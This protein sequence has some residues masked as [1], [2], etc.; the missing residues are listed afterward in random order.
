MSLDSRHFIAVLAVITALILVFFFMRGPAH[1][2]NFS[3]AQ[4]GPATDTK[5]RTVAPK[6]EGTSKPYYS[7]AASAKISNF[8]PP[9]RLDK[10]YDLMREGNY[11]KSM[12]ELNA[13]GKDPN[14]MP[15]E[16]DLIEFTK[17]QI[18]FTSKNFVVAREM[19]EKFLKENPT[20]PM[21]ENAQKA[22]EFIDNY[23]KYKS[24][25]KKFEDDLKK[26]YH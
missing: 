2:N 16:K 15:D 10:I 18:Y 11:E 26:T 23:D 25:Y 12:L 9:K 4:D 6:T 24:E 20:H 5:T 21:S 7:D 17:A 1:K 13:M 19:F 3:T 14:L 8:I 22:I